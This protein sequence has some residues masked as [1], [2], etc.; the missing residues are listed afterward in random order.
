MA[1]LGINTA[2]ETIASKSSL[3]VFCTVGKGQ[4]V[5]SECVFKCIKY[6][7]SISKYTMNK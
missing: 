1:N 6:V 3:V 5:H 7:A 2:K 4:A